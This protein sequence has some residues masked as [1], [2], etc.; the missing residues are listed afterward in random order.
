MKR[1]KRLLIV[2]NKKQQK[3][4]FDWTMK[5]Q[6]TANHYQEFLKG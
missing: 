2:R 3:N 4:S 1:D 6:T 5:N